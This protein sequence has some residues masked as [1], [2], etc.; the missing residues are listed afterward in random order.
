[1]QIS[2]QQQQ[3]LE[4][5]SNIGDIDLCCDR[6]GVSKYQFA[7]WI[8]DSE[9]SQAY[10]NCRSFLIRQLEDSLAIKGLKSLEQALKFGED[11][12]TTTSKETRKEVLDNEGQPV[13]LLNVERKVIKKHT[14]LPGWAVREALRIHLLQKVENQTLNALA[15]LITEGLL[16]RE[17]EDQAR[18]IL[19]ETDRKIQDLIGG[20][21]EQAEITKDDLARIQQMILRGN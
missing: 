6:V 2:N 20:K 3:F 18:S 17:L 10:S 15:H 14:K 8:T 13:E 19:D 5:F 16:P 21:L 12:V 4:E 9:F 1:M 7:N 11:T